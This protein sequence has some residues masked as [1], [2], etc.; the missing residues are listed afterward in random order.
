MKREKLINSTLLVVFCGSIL[1]P[2]TSLTARKTT[3]EQINKK[4]G[5]KPG[6]TVVVDIDFG[7]IEVG[8]NATSEVVVDV[9]RK[10]GRSSKSAEEK[11]LKDNPVNFSQDG[12]T[13]TISSK[14]KTKSNWSWTGRNS[15]EA[16]YVITVPAKFNAR[17]ETAGVMVLDGYRFNAYYQSEIK[18][19]CRL[20]VMDD[21]G[22]LERYSADVVVNQNVHAGEGLYAG[23]VTPQ[24]RLLLGPQYAMLRN[25]FAAYRDWTREVTEV[26]SRV[27]LTMGGSDPSDFAPRILPWL[28]RMRG[29]E[30]W[31]RVV[32]GGGAGKG[33]LEVEQA[34]SRD[35]APAVEPHQVL[36]VVIAQDEHALRQIE[37]PEGRAPE[38][39]ILGTLVGAHLAAGSGG[40]E[41]FGKQVDFDL[42]RHRV[43][44]EQGQRVG[45]R[46]IKR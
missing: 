41:P 35:A 14:N 45:A 26:G 27:L 8:T 7:S 31:A 38:A 15:N 30:L 44:G 42:H 18:R 19:C 37:L 29:N 46:H 2:L 43:V 40:I 32:V 9:W 11:F 1:I 4:F 13:V 36:G 28:A 22:Q 39:E 25:E 23:R 16:K 3:E 34:R 21:E 24:T 17:L 20:L 5:V 6:G 33:V 10:I 12:D